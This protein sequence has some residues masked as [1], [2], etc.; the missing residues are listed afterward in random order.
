MERT[1]LYHAHASGVSG[2]ITLPF[3]EVIPVQAPAAIPVTGG[4]SATRV[5]NFRHRD[6]VSFRSATSIV[7]GDFSA[8]DQAYETLMSATIEGLNIL[9]VVTADVI[10]AR[11]SSRH[12][13]DGGEPSIIPLG[14]YFENL[15]IAGCKVEAPLNND[16]FM[17][18][19]RYQDLRRVIDEDAEV[20]SR[21]S[22]GFADLSAQPRNGALLCSL[23]G[24][25]T[26]NCR[27]LK[28]DGHAIHVPQFGTVYLAEFLI[29]PY[30]RSI[31]MLR[32]ELGSPVQGQVTSGGG[33]GNG[34]PYPP[35]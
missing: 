11:L 28:A 23:A 31:T 32:A 17:R 34:E 13:K 9:D 21:L 5:E 19:P 2:R 14:S 1:F 8:R 24:D 25:V 30:S 22:R 26:V 6:I 10:V 18:C 20:R 35:T 3:D 12:P 29:T 33:S 15:R 27:E 4:Y 7:S 16:Q